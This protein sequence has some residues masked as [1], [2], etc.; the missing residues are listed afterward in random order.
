MEY[1]SLR[2]A[3][4]CLHHTDQIDNF[5]FEDI[6]HILCPVINYNIWQLENYTAQLKSITAHCIKCQAHVKA[7][8]KI[9]I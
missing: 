1:R 5:L 8:Q 4:I 6:E 7:N 9:P 2:Q 3:I